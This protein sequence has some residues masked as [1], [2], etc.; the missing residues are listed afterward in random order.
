MSKSINNKAMFNQNDE[1]EKS[2]TYE[3]PNQK[4]L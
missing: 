1:S 2:R 3:Q 4:L